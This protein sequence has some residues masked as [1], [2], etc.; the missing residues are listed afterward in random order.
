VTLESFEA[1]SPRLQAAVLALA[2]EGALARPTETRRRR[3][4]TMLEL[5]KKI[6]RR[7]D[8]SSRPGADRLTRML[9]GALRTWPRD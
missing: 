3:I 9:E 5:S 6:A 7:S 1:A 2:F 4:V 8:A